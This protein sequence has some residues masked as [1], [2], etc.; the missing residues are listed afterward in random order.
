M[1]YK[2][3]FLDS[4]FVIALLNKKDRHFEKANQKVDFLF[5]AKEVWTK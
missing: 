3:V 1:E 5:R 2:R 4:S